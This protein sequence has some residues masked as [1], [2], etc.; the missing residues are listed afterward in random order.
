MLEHQRDP[1]VLRNDPVAQQPHTA[2]PST[3]KPPS[4]CGPE[5]PGFH[6]VLAF[7]QLLTRALGIWGIYLMAVAAGL[8]AGPACW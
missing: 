2:T 3:T 6:E 8:G 1:A 7:E 4:P 5:R